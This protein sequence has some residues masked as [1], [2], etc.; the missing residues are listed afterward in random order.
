MNKNLFILLLS[1]CFYQKTLIANENN[2]FNF[3]YQKN[4]TPQWTWAFESLQD[5]KF[6]VNDKVLDV[7]CG[8]GKTSSYIA[9]QLSQGFVLGIDLIEKKISQANSVFGFQN[10]LLFMQT[11]VCTISFKE[12]FDKIVSF[13]SLHWILN[14]ER[15]LKCMVD[16]LKSKGYMLIVL[17]GATPNNLTTVIEKVAKSKKWISYFDSYQQD[18]FY[19]T[20]EEFEALLKKMNLNIHSVKVRDKYVHYK[21]K[22][23][24]IA[25]FRPLVTCIDHLRTDLK[26]MFID[27]IANQMLE[28]DPPHA[29]GSFDIH[30]VL[31]E[32]IAQKP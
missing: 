21:S 9:E 5:F 3:D 6:D 12:K 24:L 29:D 23:A 20:A 13:C 17:P 15:A 8:E 26:E 2:S 22:E 25:W 31:I 32:V 1:I 11:D 18:R 4:L 19:Q 7:G 30:L 14:Q 27:D 16:S 10:N 28:N